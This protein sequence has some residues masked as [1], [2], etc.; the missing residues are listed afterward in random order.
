MIKT[1]GPYWGHTQVDI[2]RGLFGEHTDD[3]LRTIVGSLGPGEYASLHGPAD[4][5]SHGLHSQ[6]NTWQGG[7]K[8]S[9]FT[10]RI[11]E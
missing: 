9:G 10:L 3:L 1:T 6:L 11:L 7:V 4:H 5:G 8:D 2:G